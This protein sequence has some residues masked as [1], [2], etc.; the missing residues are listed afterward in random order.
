MSN[1]LTT[2]FARRTNPFVWL[3]SLLLFAS[4]VTRIAFVCQTGGIGTGAV[5]F[6]IILPLA[7][8]LAMIIQLLTK[9]ERQFYRTRGPV[10]VFAFAFIATSLSLHRM[11]L[12]RAMTALLIVLS[13]FQAMLYWFTYGGSLGTQIP[14]FLAY[15]AFI[16]LFVAFPGLKVLLKGWFAL[17]PMAVAADLTLCAAIVAAILASRRMPPWKEGDPYRLRPGDRADGRLLRSLPPMSR[18]SPYIMPD[19]NGASNLFH[20]SIEI[21][22]MERY[23]RE[24]RR[25]GLKHFG[26]THVFIASYVRGCALMPGLNR[27]LSGQKVYHRFGI[28]V[29]MT[30]KKSLEASSPDTC[31]KI[32]FLPTDTAEDV[33]RKFDEALK[34]VKESSE[35]D[36]DFDKLAETLLLIPG[37][38]FKFTIW[39]LKLLD[40]FGMLPEF[41]T[42]LSPFHGSMFITALGSLGIEPVYHHLYDFGN[43]TQFCAFGCKRTEKTVADDGTIHTKKYVDCTWVVDERTIDG[44][45]Y[46]AACKKIKYILQHPDVL[47][48]HVVPVEDIY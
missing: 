10:L 8:N 47:D 19:R 16:P 32:K 35:L 40:Y 4:F 42:D 25:Q 23:I 30:V 20:D 45:Y 27:F 22:N 12:S 28:D 5:V 18:V 41:L 9:G 33:Y 24:K 46:A 39:L 14:V 48:E 21:T 2:Y 43:V 1:N 13:L 36:S 31:I 29:N 6:R 11:G 34:P 26:I 7:A 17:Q 3:A 44:F 37:V 15:M 38:F